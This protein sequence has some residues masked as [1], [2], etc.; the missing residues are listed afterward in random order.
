M[1]IALWS[2][3]AIAFTLLIGVCVFARRQAAVHARSSDA[4]KSQVVHLAA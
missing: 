1:T 4:D 3:M 2:Q